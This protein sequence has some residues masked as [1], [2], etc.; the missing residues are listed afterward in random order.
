M[1]TK[2]KGNQ[3]TKATKAKVEKTI[4]KETNSVHLNDLKDSL[5]LNNELSA[6]IA[7]SNLNKFKRS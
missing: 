7:L 4:A 1:N 5:K 6:Q 3:L 2:L